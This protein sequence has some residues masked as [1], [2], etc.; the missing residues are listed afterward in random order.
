MPTK[1]EFN[2]ASMVKGEVLSQDVENQLKAVAL[3]SPGSTSARSSKILENLLLTKVYTYIGQSIYTIKSGMHW[4][5]AR[6][7]EISIKYIRL[8]ATS[9]G[10]PLGFP[11]LRGSRD[12]I[13]GR[14]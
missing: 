8:K 2:N 14:S 1:V 12:T 9:S 6:L 10:I 7:P 5:S 13:S 11:F 4:Q 3:S